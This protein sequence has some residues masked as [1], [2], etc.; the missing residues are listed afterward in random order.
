MQDVVRQ[1]VGIGMVPWP[2]IKLTGLQRAKTEMGSM[3]WVPCGTTHHHVWAM[4][5]SA[6]AVLWRFKF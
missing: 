5:P 2:V 6:P 1:L 3:W 4:L